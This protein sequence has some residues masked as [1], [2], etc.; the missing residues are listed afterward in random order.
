[1]GDSLSHNPRKIVTARDIAMFLGTKIHGEDVEINSVCSLDSIDERSLLFSK[2][3]LDGKLLSGY[4]QV[5]LITTELPVDVVSG[6]FI[7]VENPRL[8]FAKVLAEFFLKKEKPGIGKHS[9]VAPSAK[10][11][12]DVSIGNNCTIGE[13]VVIGDKTIIRNNVVI[14]DDVKIG[15]NCL[16]RSNCVIG[17]EGFG[18]ED[19]KDGTP[20][21]IPHLGSVKIGDFVE[22]GNFT[23]IAC[24]TLKDTTI[25]SHVKI[26]NLVH[27]AHNCVIG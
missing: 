2:T 20:V 18:F 10:I 17:E 9:V 26:D 21:R 14:A 15:A 1:M 4:S 7:L 11:G 5:C 24:G 25:G 3:K 8:A 6:T 23:A 19:D 13:N 16:L 22:V 12:Q 27:I